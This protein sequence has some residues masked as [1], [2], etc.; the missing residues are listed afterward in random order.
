MGNSVALLENVFLETLSEDLFIFP[1]VEVI[2]DDIN[3]PELEIEIDPVVIEPVDPIVDTVSYTHL[4]LPT[5]C[6]V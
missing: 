5:I 6:S 1:E 2:V 4:T 3:D